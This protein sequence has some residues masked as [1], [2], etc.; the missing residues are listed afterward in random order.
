MYIAISLTVHDTLKAV[1]LIA[2]TEL[3]VGALGT[4]RER[5]WNECKQFNLPSGSVSIVTL[6]GI[7]VPTI[8]LTVLITITVKLYVVNGWRFDIVISVPETGSF[9]SESEVLQ[10]KIN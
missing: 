10:W 4:E 5:D 9:L 8:L 1:E 7:L 6:T 2:A 3:R